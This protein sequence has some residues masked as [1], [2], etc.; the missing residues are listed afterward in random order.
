MDWK[1][2]LQRRYRAALHTRGF[3]LVKYGVRLFR[4]AK[5]D[6]NQVLSGE[7][8]A[9]F[10]A[11]HM[12]LDCDLV[13]PINDAAS[14]ALMSLKATCLLRAGVL[15]ECEVLEIVARAARMIGS[16]GAAAKKAA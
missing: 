1:I 6:A 4:N 5:F 10:G 7:N 9:L 13:F 16:C 15:D 8:L 2:G 11:F 3:P 12:K 14:A